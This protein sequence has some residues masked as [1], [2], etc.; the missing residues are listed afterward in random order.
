MTTEEAIKVLK[1][2]RRV[3]EIYESEDIV[4]YDMAISALTEK[5][6][7]ENEEIII[8]DDAPIVKGLEWEKEQESEEEE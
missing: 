7:I 5:A 1:K 2:I 8:P 4:A 6:E 3:A